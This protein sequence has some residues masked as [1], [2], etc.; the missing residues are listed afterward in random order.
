MSDRSGP[1]LD[2]LVS[3]PHDMLAAFALGAIEGADSLRAMHD[4]LR[5]NATP[6]LIRWLAEGVEMFKHYASKGGEHQQTSIG[7][8]ELLKLVKAI[9]E[10]D[11]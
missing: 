5:D 8:Q 10:Q 1:T 11:R 4:K 7:A 3:M 6:D 9:V 2:Q